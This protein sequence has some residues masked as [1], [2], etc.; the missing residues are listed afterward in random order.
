M[1]N[2]MFPD[3][4]ATA[5]AGVVLREVIECIKHLV[6]P[7][8]V[9]YYC[10]SALIQPLRHPNHCTAILRGRVLGKHEGQSRALCLRMQYLTTSSKT[11]VIVYLLHH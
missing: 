1:G 5:I 3:M 4:R 10:G 6:L 11:K 2:K 9:V 8:S 7:R